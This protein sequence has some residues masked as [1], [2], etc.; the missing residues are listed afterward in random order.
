MV[1]DGIDIKNEKTLIILSAKC[2]KNGKLNSLRKVGANE[3][4]VIDLQLQSLNI[5]FKNKYV[6]LGENHEEWNRE[7]FKKIINK[8]WASSNSGFSL[9]KA[10]NTIKP[11]GEIWILYSDIL[12]REINLSKEDHDKN[13]IYVDNEWETRIKD[14]KTRDSSLIE[15]VKSDKD[16]NINFFFTGINKYIKQTAELCG[17]IKLENNVFN[18]IR[19]IIKSI[20]TKELKKLST[21]ELLEI[22][23]INGINYHSRNIS[24]KY[25]QL[26]IDDDLIKFFLGTKAETLEKLKLSGIKNGY[27][28]DQ[29]K[30]TVYDWN[31]SQDSI[32]E[33][34]TKQF[35]DSCIVVRSSCFA[36]DRSDYSSAGKYESQLAVD[37]SYDSIKRSVRKVIQ[38]YDVDNFSKDQLLVQKFLNNIDYSGVAFSRMIENNGPYIS[39]NISSV[40]TTQVTSGNSC[41]EFFIHRNN[42]HLVKEN[43]L[44]KIV[45]CLLEIEN[46]LN[47]NF[48]DM[49]FAIVK[50]KLYILQVR[51]LVIK[52]KECNDNLI[53]KFLDQ[54]NYVI[55]KSFN[56]KN[57]I[58]SLMSDWNPAEIIGKLPSKLSSSIYKYII[59]DSNWAL[60]RKIDNYKKVNGPLLINILGTDYVDVNKSIQSFI[61]SKIPDDISIKIEEK[62]YNALCENPSLHDK[63]EFE[64]IPT[65]IDLNWEKWSNYFKE[66]LS[67]KE[68]D[69]YKKILIKNTRDI[70]NETIK[71]SYQKSI[72]ELI[73]V[74]VVDPKE[75]II[76]AIELIDKIKNTLAVEFARSARR[77]FIVSSWLKSGLEKNI[78]S[79]RAELGFYKSLHTI[80]SEFI[81]DISNKNFS[82]DAI[83]KKYGHLR[84][85]SYDI[86]S[87]CY[88]ERELVN[89]LI[90]DQRENLDNDEDIK[91]WE[92]EKSNLINKIKILLNLESNEFVEKIMKEN[93]ILRE[94]NK[95]EFTKL[96]SSALELIA[97][98]LNSLGIN[99]KSASNLNLQTLK[100]IAFSKNGVDLDKSLLEKEIK[101]N[102]ENRVLFGFINKPE[103]IIS[104]KELLFDRSINCRPTFIGTKVIEAT[105]LKLDSIQDEKKLDLNNKIIL[106]ENADPGYDFIFGYKIKGLITMYG[107][108][109][110]H[111]TIRCSE[112]NV[113]AVI[114]LGHKRYSEIEINNTF[115]INPN[116]KII[117]KI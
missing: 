48:I 89:N 55:N 92:E 112:L 113:T 110:S 45:E 66:T 61:P 53:N 31:T 26:N 7:D 67:I 62:A 86:Q 28:L 99:R 14:R 52:N 21:S 42:T 106:I 44:K 37:C 56:K 35:Q 94:R 64:I 5:E 73:K 104:G 117:R 30:F 80:S 103:I 19:S 8:D 20:D 95:F 109:N 41:H 85:S 87:K 51:P 102:A 36:E 46:L 90:K 78:I 1:R 100:D 17:I 108:S 91:A 114:G 4:T 115:Q 22:T 11:L 15:L 32:L 27:F 71:S 74:E 39:I 16:K 69:I 79:K 54:S 12:F 59:T 47:Y 2:D 93:V 57:Q 68:L 23:R 101:L 105:I 33:K 88:L 75:K 10:L 24:G 76:I 3:N 60:S 96:L 72:K 38:S 40:D 25:C 77:A 82:K 81:E 70:M 34:I 65:C 63:L 18:E 43:N 49:E 97:N 6:V 116:L 84:P 58:F 13:I 98:Y 107:G 50:Q 9:S 29:Y 83:Y 111:M